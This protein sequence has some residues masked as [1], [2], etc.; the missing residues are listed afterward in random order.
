[1]K[2]RKHEFL[3]DYFTSNLLPSPFFFGGEGWSRVV[4]FL[5]S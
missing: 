3:E 2:W 5:L 1:M 4:R